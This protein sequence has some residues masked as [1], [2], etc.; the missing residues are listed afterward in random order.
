M[1]GNSEWWSAV[2]WFVAYSNPISG[3]STR[4]NHRSQ[5]VASRR[6]PQLNPWWENPRLMTRVDDGIYI[7]TYTYI[8][9]SYIPWLDSSIPSIPIIVITCKSHPIINKPQVTESSSKPSHSWF[10]HTKKNHPIHRFLAAELCRTPLKSK[11]PWRCERLPCC[12]CNSAL[13]LSTCFESLS[14]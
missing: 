6:I 4:T 2:A 10:Y 11:A 8:Y 5:R 3:E 14:T 13:V 1:S 7:Y 9:I 12:S